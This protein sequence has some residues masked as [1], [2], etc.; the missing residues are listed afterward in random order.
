[1]RG[2]LFVVPIAAVAVGCAAEAVSE[3][4]TL[5]ACGEPSVSM[6][7]PPVPLP[8]LGTFVTAAAP[9]GTTFPP[10][11]T[12]DRVGF[13]EGYRATFKQFYVFDRVDMRSVVFV[14]A[15][16]IAAEVGPGEEFPHGSVLLMEN[17]NPVT[18]E[19]G[20]LVRDAEGRLIRSEISVIAVMRKEAGFGE[21]YQAARSG[22]W[23]YVM[24]WPDGTHQT[25]PERSASCASCHAV[26]AGAERDF[27]FR[28]NIRFLADRYGRTD[29]VD[30]GEIGVSRMAY[31]P[32]NHTVPVGTTV[33][34]RNSTIDETRHSVTASDGSFISDLLEPGEAFSHT[35][36]EPGS[37]EYTC[38]LHPA[39]MRGVVEVTG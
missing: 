14:C 38:A 29:P 2:T 21:A 30:E 12:A 7:Q 26:G 9:P 35:F 18:D 32:G 24:Y 37:Y 5:P 8:E 27:V 23:E 11:P 10:A 22:E 4:V 6:I 16:D 36:T 13:P 34:W 20:N 31:R 39:Q 15:N 17:W 19:D 1:M 28:T 33:V 3:V 25:P